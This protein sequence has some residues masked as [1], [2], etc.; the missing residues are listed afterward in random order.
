MTPLPRKCLKCGHVIG[1][2]MVDYPVQPGESTSTICPVCMTPKVRELQ[3]RRG[4]FDC[5]GTAIGGC[6]QGDCKYREWCLI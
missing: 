5:F 1:A 3:R 4:Y 2:V 6:S